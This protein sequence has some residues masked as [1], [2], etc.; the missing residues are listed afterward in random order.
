VKST[1]V[2]EGPIYLAA[3]YSRAAE[4]QG[5]R[6]V[7]QALGYEVTARWIDHHGGKYPGSFTPAQLNDDPVYCADIAECDL[8]DLRRAET[9]ISFTCADNGGKGG[10]HVEYGAALA[11]NKKLVIVGPRENVFHA[12][13]HVT[14][15][16][17]WPQLARDLSAPVVSAL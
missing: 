10:R 17:T 14:H 1:T 11:L 2:I 9:V 8:E 7:M 3:R 6:D 16:H 13:P 12:L 15:Y 5:V 4:M